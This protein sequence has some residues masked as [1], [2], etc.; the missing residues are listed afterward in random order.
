[1]PVRLAV[2][3]LPGALSD[4]LSDPVLVPTAVGVNVTLIVQLVF[5]GRV[6]AQVFADT[7]KSPLT[8][9]EI[10]CTETLW[11][12]VRVKFFATLVVP[13]VCAL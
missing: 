12:L 6:A 5:A 9:M 13:T 1:V 10:L 3:G 7:A 4:T 2:C 8:E 11:W